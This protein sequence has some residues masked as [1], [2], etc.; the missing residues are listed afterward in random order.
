M[1]FRQGNVVIICEEEDKVCDFCGIVS[2]TRP[3]GPNGE[4]ICFECGT[5]DPE[6]TERRMLQHLFGER[7]DA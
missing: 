7:F 6:M 1:S 2:E 5:K 4:E 3:Y